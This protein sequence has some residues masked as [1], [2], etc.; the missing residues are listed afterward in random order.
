M[1]YI[2][3]YWTRFGNNKR[4]V[5]H[6][7]GILQGE[8]QAIKADEADP[9]SIPEADYYIFS[10]A[11]EKFTVQKHMRK[12]MKGLREMDGR[13]YGI[14]N[15]HASNKSWLPKM[16]KI[17]SKKGMVKVAEIDFQVVGGMNDQSRIVDGWEEKLDAFASKLK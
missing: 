16:E 10:A 11:A 3:V 2:I 4:I 8:V 13:K 5:D 1:R 15:T 14:I 12:Y 6:L 7:A 9:L 17:L